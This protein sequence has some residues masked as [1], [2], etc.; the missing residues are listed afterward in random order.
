ML[1]QS[2]CCKSMAA[3]GAIPRGCPVRGKLVVV[4]YGQAQDL[5]LRDARD[6]QPRRV[7]RCREVCYNLFRKV[8]KRGRCCIGARSG[9]SFSRDRVAGDRR[10]ADHFDS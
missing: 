3:V 8:R 1:A 6:R 7:A 9:Y 2:V 10:R 4:Q 5:P